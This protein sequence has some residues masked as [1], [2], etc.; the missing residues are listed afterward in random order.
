MK[1]V[2]GLIA[3]LIIGF[4]QPALAESKGAL[5]AEIRQ[6]I[7]KFTQI[8][9]GACNFLNK[10]AGYIV[11]PNLYKAGFVV[12]GEYGEG[13]LLVR[14]QGFTS[15]GGSASTFRVAS[16]YSMFSASI[17]FQLGAQKRSLIV[18]FTSPSALR[19]FKNSA[20]WKIG[21]DS[22]VTLINV[23]GNLDLSTMDFEQPVVAFAFN[24]Q[25]LMAGI[26]LDGSVFKRI[27][28]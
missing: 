28:K 1:K 8:V 26:S 12:G 20:K 23:G 25:G 3:V 18:A 9:P 10:T 22:S 19:T 11:I 27:K 7:K 17:G 13:G 24:N 5:D 16:Y 6:T 15:C 21:V 2:I 4:V 14:E